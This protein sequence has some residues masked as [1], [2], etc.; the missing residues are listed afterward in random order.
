MAPDREPRCFG[1]DL[2]VCHP[3]RELEGCECWCRRGTYVPG[4]RRPHRAAML[5]AVAALAAGCTSSGSAEPTVSPLPPSAV[6]SSGLSTPATLGCAWYTPTRIAGQVV[7]V[8]ATG[9]ACKDRSVIDMLTRD[10]DQPWMTEG[11]IPGSYGRQLAVLKHNGSTIQIWFTGPLP[12]HDKT[13]SP[14]TQSDTPAAELA[15]RIA[16]SF[17]DAGWKPVAPS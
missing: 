4:C 8:T 7:S 15:G 14:G 3:G 1:C 11:L 6:G 13:A 10:T 16:Q 2:G 5:L 9:P 17:Q 12:S